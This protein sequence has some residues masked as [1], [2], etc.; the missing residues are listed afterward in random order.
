MKRPL[1]F[2]KAGAP[3]QNDAKMA[4]QEAKIQNRLN[5]ET[6]RQVQLQQGEAAIEAAK[7]QQPGVIYPGQ[8][9]APVP[10]APAQ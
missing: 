2:G 6:A 5:Q 3:K 10:V 1:L 4:E 7:N 8:P 9:V